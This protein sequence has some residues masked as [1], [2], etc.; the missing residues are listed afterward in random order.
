M[1]PEAQ[2]EVTPNHE[3]PAKP[4][5]VMTTEN[6]NR[7]DIKFVWHLAMIGSMLL[8]QG[9]YVAMA[10]LSSMTTST[11]SYYYGNNF[12]FASNSVGADT[13]TST[14]LQTTQPTMEAAS[15]A[16]A[17]GFSWLA[18]KLSNCIYVLDVVQILSWQRKLIGG[19]VMVFTML[20]IDI[21]LTIF[22]VQI[23]A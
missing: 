2:P 10:F 6:E 21:L 15:V 4:L 16:K 13:A 19:L 18:W 5:T 9:L 14:T 7:E 12:G 17:V 22:L 20:A 3:E 1:E 23:Y 8:A 11:I